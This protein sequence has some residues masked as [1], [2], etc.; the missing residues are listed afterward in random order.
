MCDWRHYQ[1]ITSCRN[2]TESDL[3]PST[4]RKGDHFHYK[5]TLQGTI[6]HVL[7]ETQ[8]VNQNQEKKNNLHWNQFQALLAIFSSN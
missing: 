7:E 3:E 8:H 1:Y 5:L 2:P 4:Y 6:K